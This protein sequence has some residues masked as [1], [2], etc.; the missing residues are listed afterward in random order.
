MP[1]GGPNGAI[2]AALRSE[3]ATA[4]ETVRKVHPAVLKASDQRLTT[5]PPWSGVLVAK[6]G[7]QAR[8]DPEVAIRHARPRQ[9]DP[10]SVAFVRVA[11]TTWLPFAT[12]M[13]GVAAC[14]NQTRGCS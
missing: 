5:M 4:A 10:D 8:R 3:R 1:A 12:P 13:R 14:G 2:K 7:S 9:T 11:S 6:Y